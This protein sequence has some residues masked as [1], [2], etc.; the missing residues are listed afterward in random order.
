MLSDCP[1]V[2]PETARVRFMGFGESSLEVEVFCHIR[3]TALPEFLAVREDLLLRIMKLVAAEGIEF[4]IP[5][6]SLYLSHED[7]KLEER[8]TDDRE[9]TVME[10]PSSLETFKRRTGT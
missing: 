10:S 2:Y 6:R 5:S 3:T 8:R 7:S 4:A 1:E 9:N